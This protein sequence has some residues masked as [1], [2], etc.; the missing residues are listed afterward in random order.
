M[1]RKITK[2]LKDKK[3]EIKQ[4]DKVQDAKT[5]NYERSDLEE[6]KEPIKTKQ[7]R[8]SFNIE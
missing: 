7:R 1:H 5:P 4:N 2:I 3:I 8:L 6:F